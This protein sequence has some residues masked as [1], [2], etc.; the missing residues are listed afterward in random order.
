M[1]T[2]TG[3][4]TLIR[5][6]GV[7]VD[8]GHDVQALSARFDKQFEGGLVASSV[9]QMMGLMN[10]ALGSGGYVALERIEGTLDGRAGSFC[11]Q[12]SSTM[13][14]GSPTQHLQVVPDSGTDGLLGL[15]GTMRIDIVDGRHDYT[16][17][18]DIAEA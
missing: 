14:R 6:P 18:Y 7:P 10:Q 12:H 4:F 13:E 16:F 2:A 17:E 15:R 9:V 11:L 3:S 1:T 5:S 8:L